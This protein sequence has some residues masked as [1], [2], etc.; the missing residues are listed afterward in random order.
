MQAVE[1]VYPGALVLSASEGEALRLAR[2]ATTSAA[3]GSSVD[4]L[5]ELGGELR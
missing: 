3:A 4:W 5:S 1:S 2:D